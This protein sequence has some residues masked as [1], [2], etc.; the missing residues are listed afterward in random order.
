VTVTTLEDRLRECVGQVIEEESVA[1]DPVNVPMI[2]NWCDAL[3]DSDAVYLDAGSARGAGYPGIVAPPAMLRTW[4][5]APPAEQLSPPTGDEASVYSVLEDAGYTSKAATNCDQR[6]VRYLVPGDVV[7]SRTSLVSVSAEKRTAIGVG[8]FIDTETEF[9]DQRGD[10]VA[11]M[12]WRSLRFRPG[13]GRS[14]VSGGRSDRLAE[15]SAA[16]GD[17]PLGPV[18]WRVA[19]T[20]TLIIFGATASRDYQ[21]VHHDRDLARERGMPD[22]F[23]NMMTSGGLVSRYVTDW[24]GP[25]GRLLDLRL[26][27]GVPNHPGDTMVLRTVD[28]APG[29]APGTRRLVIDGTNRLGRHVRA[30]VT[31]AGAP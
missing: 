16:T 15:A 9:R 1:R 3:G 22:I 4:T 10:I 20:P 5:M 14:S 12:R 23:M 6:F 7:R 24:T 25:A 18:P 21:D 19:V 31:V 26:T 11:Q 13:T 28:S 2:R 30:E 27:L 29:E 17:P 8:C